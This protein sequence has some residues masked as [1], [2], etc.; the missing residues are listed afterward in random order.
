[1]LQAPGRFG[2]RARLR[3]PL[4][5]CFTGHGHPR[6][7]RQAC[8]CFP[9]IGLS[10]GDVA[11]PRFRAKV[12]FFLAKRSLWGTHDSS[13]DVS[14]SRRPLPS[15]SRLSRSTVPFRPGVEHLVCR[16]K[17]PREFFFAHTEPHAAVAAVNP[18]DLV[19]PTY[20]VF[21]TRTAAPIRA[22]LD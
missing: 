5:R 2:V 11:E 17:N 3:F 8:L 6:L 10:S 4:V 15:P 12:P 19:R 20:P 18:P 16:P 9:R 7:R 22:A 1:V 21:A 14:P 13:R